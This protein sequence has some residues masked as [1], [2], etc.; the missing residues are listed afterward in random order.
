MNTKT[1][2]IAAAIGGAL[3]YM[4]KKKMAGA[5]VAGAAQ[6]L[7][8]AVVDVADGAVSGVVKGAGGLFGIPDTNPSQCAADKAAGNTWD[9]SFSCSAGDFFGHLWG[10][11]TPQSS[12]STKQ[13]ITAYERAQG[14]GSGSVLDDGFWNNNGGT[15]KGGGQSTDQFGLG[16]G[17]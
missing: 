2:L 4:L 16:I 14:S 10:S 6:A 13:S 7:G 17:F 3:L 9:A 8:G 5:T 12:Q 11:D 15:L 1:I